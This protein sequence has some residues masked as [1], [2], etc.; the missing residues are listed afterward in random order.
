VS[1]RTGRKFLEYE[2]IPEVYQ[3]QPVDAD[4]IRRGDEIIRAYER[5]LAGWPL[6]ERPSAAGPR[7]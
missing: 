5:K 3:V 4:P 6:S 7:A 2:Q 1:L